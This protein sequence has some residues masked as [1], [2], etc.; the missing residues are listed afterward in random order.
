MTQMPIDLDLDLSGLPQNDWLGRLDELGDEHGYFEQLGS[1]HFALFIDAGPQLLVTFETPEV[2]QQNPEGRPRGFD[3]V[4]QHGWS[5]LALISDGDTWFRDPAVY[6]FFDRLTDDGFFD[7]F[8]SVLFFGIGAGGYAAAAFSVATPGAQV[9]AIR[10]QATL[11]P[12][13]TGWDKRFVA[14][15]RLDFNSRYGYAPDMLDAADRAFVLCDPGYAPDAL[16]AGLFRRPNVTMLRCPLLGQRP[17]VGLDA[18]QLTGPLIEQAMDGSLTLASFGAL[19][20]ARRSN[21]NYMRGL[22]K[23]AELAGRADFVRRL[24]N[25]GLA[26]RDSAFYRRKLQELDA[27]A[28]V[29]P[30]ANA[31]E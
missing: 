24:C 26:T 22:L 23:K 10:P 16:Q 27:A 8:A 15:R 7:R 4:S 18:M 14:K 28:A 17:E 19:W 12:A 21:P 20:R 29:Q 30:A 9:L 1:K 13:Q 11:D 5:H 3:F 2:A 6:R 25:Q 31:A